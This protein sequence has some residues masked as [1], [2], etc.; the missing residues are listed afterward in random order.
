MK[1]ILRIVLFLSF[2]VSMAQ[3][4]RKAAN[5]EYLWGEEN[6][7]DFNAEI[8]DIIAADTSAV[9]LLKKREQPND[10][11]NFKI[12][13][14]TLNFESD[15]KMNIE[16]VSTA[17][18]DEEL[19]F[20]IDYND[21]LQIFTSFIDRKR[22]RNI[23]YV[24]T[25]NKVLLIPEGN[26]R[27]VCSTDYK[28]FYNK[29]SFGYTV[30]KDSSKLLIYSALPNSFND[31]EKIEIS[32]FDK[33]FR[34]ISQNSY[35][36]KYD[37]NLGEDRYYYVDNQGNAYILSLVKEENEILF[38]RE[39]EKN[40]YELMAFT[41]RGTKTRVYTFSVK[42]HYISDFYVITDLNGDIVLTGFYS[43]KNYTGV[44]GTVYYKIRQ[45]TD[46]INIVRIKPFSTDFLARFM[47]K[48]KAEKGN[49]LYDFYINQ[50]VINSKNEI[51]M[52][53]EQQFLSHFSYPSNRKSLVYNYN[54]LIVA[55]FDSLGR[56]MWIN[57]VS[58]Q[59]EDRDNSG[60]FSSYA[61]ME[62][63]DSL[64]FFFND[65]P[66]NLFNKHPYKVFNFERYKESLLVMVSIA[67]DGSQN[68]VPV[69][70]IRSDELFPRPKLHNLISRKKM[71]IIAQDRRRYT[72]LT[73]SLF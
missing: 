13:R 51:L 59:Q 12:E 6:L 4:Q 38:S 22:R 41:E 31:S 30:S 35:I 58:K 45:N 2:I 48:R 33:Q 34:Q 66:N 53:A 64:L 67:S 1:K 61:L 32:I 14:Y 46:S 47:K 63:G 42:N 28:H 62:H 52:V 19:E 71:V 72:L 60:D 39:T 16:L 40:V 9:F 70:N 3:A 8:V 50:L 24:Q 36:L 5:V 10:E 73:L 20:I 54:S 18:N 57:K 65:N 37:E 26:R 7:M 15:L 55:K 43:E 21:K 11:E 23:L 49:E 27:E 69:L 44:A 56:Q 29:G 68:K 17:R 25:I